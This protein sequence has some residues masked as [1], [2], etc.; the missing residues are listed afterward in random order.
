MTIEGPLLST[1]LLRAI[2]AAVIVA[3]IGLCPLTYGT[4]VAQPIIVALGASNT[5][6]KTVS[7]SESYPAQLEAMLR[8]KG[9]QASVLNAGANGDTTGGMLER[10]ERDVPKGTTLV[11]LQPGGNDR[12]RG[13]DEERGGNIAA[14]KQKLAQRDIRVLMM[15]NSM[16]AAIPPSERA[17]D[18]QHF[19]PRG[20]AILASE[21]L[22]SVLRALGR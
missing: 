7:R 4:A 8:A 13:L 12:R 11:I 2:F 18:G 15:P 1:G 3:C 19:T 21:I 14:I 20:Y 16:L 9:V 22:P 17:S 5:Y 10:L 6:G